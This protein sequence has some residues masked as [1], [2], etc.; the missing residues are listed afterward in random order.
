MKKHLKWN[1]KCKLCLVPSLI[2][3][4]VFFVVTYVRVLY[5]SLIDSQ[6][7]RNFVWFDNYIDTLQNKYF[8]LALKNSL[9]LIVTAVPILM[10]LALIVSLALSYGIGCVRKTR[11]TLGAL[12]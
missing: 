8:L 2:G 10:V 1:T 4:A 9:L 7:R 12:S 3:T 11:F 6:F 5:Y